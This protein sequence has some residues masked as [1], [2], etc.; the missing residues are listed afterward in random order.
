M[1][2]F[3]IFSLPRKL[4]L[5]LSALETSFYAQS[6]KLHPDRFA[7]KPPAEQ[8]TALAASSALND[9]YRTLRDPVAR[10]EYLL[11][12]EGI[13][14]EEQSRAAT[15]LA[16]STGTEKKQVAPPDLLEEAFELNMQLEEMKF[17]PDPNTRKDLEAAREKFTG[18][19]AESQS[20][21]EAIWTQWDAAL[22]ATDDAAKTKAKDAMVA[23]LNLRSYIRNLVRDVNAA[24]E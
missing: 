2:F 4:H 16:K 11:S 12:L 13:Q 3:T 7:A 5:D 20:Q 6:R 19:L 21:L 17:D 9:A 24:L 10:T 14:L 18:M 15:D 1:D 23:L 22:D 8:E